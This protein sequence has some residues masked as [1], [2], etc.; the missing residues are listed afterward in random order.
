MNATCYRKLTKMHLFK[1][2]IKTK[3]RKRGLTAR[4]MSMLRAY[5][6]RLKPTPTDITSP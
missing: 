4:R 3:D 5:A 1:A 2:Q 6:E